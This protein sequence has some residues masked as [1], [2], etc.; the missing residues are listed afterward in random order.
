MSVI[1]GSLSKIE[2][3]ARDR[4]TNLRDELRNV[5]AQHSQL[6]SDL[7][8]KLSLEL[9]AMSTRVQGS[10]DKVAMKQR[11]DLEQQKDMLDKRI[12]STI[13]EISN[14]LEGNNQ[15]IENF[16]SEKLE[17]FKEQLAEDRFKMDTIT[18][19]KNQAFT[20]ESEKRVLNKVANILK[21]NEGFKAEVFEKLEQQ[22]NDTRKVYRETKEE[23]SLYE[24]RLN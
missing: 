3:D 24:S 5:E 6:I 15:D 23:R 2:E 18:E 12:S 19:G 1:N 8:T 21:A 11:E 13:V 22:L 14:R 17:K 9:T 10:F 4:S 7:S 16:V 20:I